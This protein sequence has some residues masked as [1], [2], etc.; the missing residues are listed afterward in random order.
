MFSKIPNKQK[1]FHKLTQKTDFTT[2]AKLVFSRPSFSTKEEN[3]PK[4]KLKLYK[5]TNK[6]GMELS[7]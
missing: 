2:T 7:L 6:Q 4:N 5:Q 3:T 1:I